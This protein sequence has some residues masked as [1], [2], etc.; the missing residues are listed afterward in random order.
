PDTSLADFVATDLKQ[1]SEWTDGLNM[2][3][4]KNIGSKDTAEFIQVL[5]EIGIKVKLLDLSGEK[6]EIP[7]SVEVPS[8]LPVITN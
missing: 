4:D 6:V 3:F 2:L 1:F 7:Q 8:E 5:T